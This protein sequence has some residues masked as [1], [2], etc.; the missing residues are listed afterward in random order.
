MP[1]FSYNTSAFQAREHT[2]ITCEPKKIYT[3]LGTSIAVEG[4]KQK[5][6]WRWLRK[7]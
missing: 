1:T 4:Q 2:E 3:C 6:V 5:R 7:C